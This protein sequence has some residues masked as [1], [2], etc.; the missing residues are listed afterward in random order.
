M[1]VSQDQDS[2][3]IS[4]ANGK[5]IEKLQ[6][7]ADEIGKLNEQINRLQGLLSSTSMVKSGMLQ[8][9]RQPSHI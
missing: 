5:T 8:S 9:Y 7:D 6:D 2:V 4:V 3:E 1:V